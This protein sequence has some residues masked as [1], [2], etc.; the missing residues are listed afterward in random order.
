MTP[1]DEAAAVL[2]IAVLVA[3][4][5][6]EPSATTACHQPSIARVEQPVVGAS[7]RPEGRTLSEEELRSIVAIVVGA[8]PHQG[9]CSGV[10]VAAESVLTAAHCVP[11][12]APAEAAAQLA[13]A[14][15]ESTLAPLRVL[16]V[17][18]VHRHADLDLALLRVEPGPC[19]DFELTPLGLADPLP[20]SW[21]DE[22]TV[23]GFG[24][25]APIGG[26]AGRLLFASERIV[27]VDTT[28]VIVEGP[29][30]M[31]GACA[32]DSGG[33]LLAADALTGKVV[34]LGTLDDGDP[35]CTGRDYFVR[36]DVSAAWLRKLND[37][38][39]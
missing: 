21:P 8:P 29:S 24:F 38:A 20:A 30:G 27:E 14:V 13:V 12:G 26:S 34:V 31:S 17:L 7:Q 1:N 18:G 37:P 11:D 10:V 16:D 35:S 33:P 19:D 36:S 9:T 6:E 2:V 15:G 28:H 23:A 25:D 39:E 5:A 3:C 22:V 4:G 32:G